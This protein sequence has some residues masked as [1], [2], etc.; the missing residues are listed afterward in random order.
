[1]SN[2]IH[3][4]GNPGRLRCATQNVAVVPGRTYLFRLYIRSETREGQFAPLV[5][6]GGVET[7][8]VLPAA[9]DKAWKMKSMVVIAKDKE[10]RLALEVNVESE[11]FEG[12]IWID[13]FFLCELPSAVKPK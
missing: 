6:L 10:I 3:G 7:P 13:D 9:C 4:S 11:R 8:D 5:G 12:S 2:R 1:M